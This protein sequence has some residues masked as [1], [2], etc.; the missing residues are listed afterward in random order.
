MSVTFKSPL[1]ATPL[2][3]TPLFGAEGGAALAPQPKTSRIAFLP[4]RK[5]WQLPLITE[6]EGGSED[7]VRGRSHGK[8]RIPRGRAKA[9]V[10]DTQRAGGT[11]SLAFPRRAASAFVLC[12]G[13]SRSRLELPSSYA[14]ARVDLPDVGLARV[15]GLEDVED[16]R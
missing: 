7:V 6:A 3:D 2:L 11:S 4:K 13:S 15:L 5:A 8:L 9:R 12:G 10:I 16:F 14:L 1:F